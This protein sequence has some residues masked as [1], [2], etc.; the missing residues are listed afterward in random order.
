M[1]MC[2]AGAIAM[3]SSYVVM[4]EEEMTYTE[5]GYEDVIE[6]KVFGVTTGIMIFNPQECSHMS[7]L[8]AG[9]ASVSGAITAV[10]PF[11]YNIPQGLLTGAFGLNSAY[12]WDCSNYGGC[13]MQYISVGKYRK[14]IRTKMIKA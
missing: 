14:I 9:G 8:L 4:N 13:I 11:P 7:A 12:M 6:K 2:Y 5:G 3:P 1:E 10:I